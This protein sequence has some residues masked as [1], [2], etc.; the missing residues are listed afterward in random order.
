MRKLAMIRDTNDGCPFGLPIPLGCKSAGDSVERM[1]PL[2]MLGKDKPEDNVLDDETNEVKNANRM[3]LSI[4]NPCQR[5]KY[6]GKVIK[7]KDKVECNF[8]SNAPGIGNSPGLVGAPFYSIV[9]NNATYDGLYSY[10]VG[11][12]GDENISRN[13]YYGLYSLQG[14]ANNP[15][16]KEA[17]QANNETSICNDNELEE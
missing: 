4:E 17:E 13:I 11:Y 10:P 9:Y 16:I 8:D 14:G 12:F 7:D 6:A 1:A 15:I 5:C 3:L 2:S